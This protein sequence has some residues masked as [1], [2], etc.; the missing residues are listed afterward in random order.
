MTLA[1]SLVSRIEIHDGH[2]TYA[3]PG[4]VMSVHIFQAAPPHQTSIKLH[5]IVGYEDGSVVLYSLD[6]DQGRKTIE[7]IGWSQLWRLHEH[8]ESGPLQL[9]HPLEL[10]NLLI[11]LQ[12]WRWHCLPVP[13]SRYPHQQIQ[14][15]SSMTCWYSLHSRFV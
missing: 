5:A 10:Y 12:L 14:N 1:L 7:G 4:A 13:D 2:L 9:L 3:R 8:K 6:G 11:G 15:S